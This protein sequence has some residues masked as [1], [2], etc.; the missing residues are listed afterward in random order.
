MAKSARER[1]TCAAGALS[2]RLRRV[3]SW[4][5]SAVSG[6]RGSFWWRDRA[7]LGTRGSPHHY[8]TS[9]GKRP[10]S[11]EKM[12]ATW[13]IGAQNEPFYK[14]GRSGDSNSTADETRG[15][16]NGLNRVQAGIIEQTKE[17]SLLGA[18]TARE[19]PHGPHHAAV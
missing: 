13:L 8:T 9:H 5:S 7:H 18:P 19:E 6:R 12:I 1:S 10:T 16:A 3:N 17:Q 15:M 4:R 11:R 14:S 2:D